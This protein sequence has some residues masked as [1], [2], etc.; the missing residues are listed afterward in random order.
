MNARTEI[1]P[2]MFTAGAEFA[3]KQHRYAVT[4]APVGTLHLPSGRV[5]TGDAIATLDFEPLSRTAPP[6]TY[7]VE[8]SLVTVPSHESLIAAVRVVFSR[9]PVARWEAAAGGTGATTPSPRGAGYTGPL[10]LLMDA[11]TVPA[12]QKY[13][14]DSAGEWWYDVPRT[15]GARWEYGC[16]QPDDDRAETCAIFQTGDGDGVFVSYWGLDASGAPV[17]LVTDFNVIP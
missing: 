15:Q 7:P 2:S 9:E 4:V 3:A 1:L 5:V 8:A 10:G 12:L 14:D 11:E 16:F 13:I 17:V 6:G